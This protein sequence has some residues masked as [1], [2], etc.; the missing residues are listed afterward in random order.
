MEKE[1]A[2]QTNDAKSKSQVLS[3]HLEEQR[4]F[5]RERRTC[6]SEVSVANINLEQNYESTCHRAITSTA[7]DDGK[8]EFVKSQKSGHRG[9]TQ[10]ENSCME[11][12]VRTGSE[13]GKE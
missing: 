1:N 11:D 4:A 5:G 9:V 6:F 3:L 12:L 2:P 8:K 13:D 7:S 10:K